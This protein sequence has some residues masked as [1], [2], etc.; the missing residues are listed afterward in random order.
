LQWNS[1][2]CRVVCHDALEKL[3]YPAYISFLIA[4]LL[5]EFEQSAELE[6]KKH[7][8]LIDAEIVNNVPM[9]VK[10]VKECLKPL[11]LMQPLLTQAF[12]YVDNLDG[13]VAL[14]SGL[15]GMPKH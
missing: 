12:H 15:V 4:A 5:E 3:A 10:D 9:L 2:C 6:T 13:C 14:V 7:Q 11:F 8:I 1:K